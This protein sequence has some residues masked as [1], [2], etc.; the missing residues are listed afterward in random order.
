M[1]IPVK[2]ARISGHL[3]G[4]YGRFYR[5]SPR[6]QADVSEVLRRVSSSPQIQRSIPTGRQPIY[7]RL[8]LLR[9]S[10]ESR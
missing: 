3:I 6:Y 8:R 1:G 2:P 7:A 5:T 10:E 4:E 9:K